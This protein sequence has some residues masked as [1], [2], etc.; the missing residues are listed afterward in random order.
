MLG[1]AGLVN[2]KVFWVPILPGRLHV[3]Q[4]AVDNSM[5]RTVF[6]VAWP[7]GAILSHAFIVYAEKPLESAAP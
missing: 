4:W 6:A 7:L 3:M 5:T 2:I 1:D